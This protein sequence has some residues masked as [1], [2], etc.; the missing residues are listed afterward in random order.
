MLPLRTGKIVPRF[1]PCRREL[2]C[3]AIPK[4]SQGQSCQSIGKTLSSGL[5]RLLSVQF[6][7]FGFVFIVI[8]VQSV[9]LY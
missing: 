7:T 3:V 4:D 2:I 1:F 5:F 8:V 6:V 9:Y